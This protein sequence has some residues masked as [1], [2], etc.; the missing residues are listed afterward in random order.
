M[1]GVLIDRASGVQSVVRAFALLEVL[2]S[3]D[4]P[5]GVTDLGAESGLSLGTIHRLLRTL[6][7]LGYVRQDPSRGYALGPGFIKLGER[8]AHGLASW[9][10][11]LL[12][13]LVRELDESV[14]LASLENDQAV[15]VAHVPSSRSMRTFTE[16]GSRV[17]VHSTGVGKAMLASM[18][19][20]QAR[21]LLGRTGMPASTVH[22][23]TDPDALVRELR[24]ISARGYALDEEEQETGVRCVAVP[25]P[26][27]RPPLAVSMSGPS[28]RVTDVLVK[29]A[30]PLLEDVADV[31]AH[32]TSRDEER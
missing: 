6:V 19:E 16:V 24:V 8:A 12:E 21:A 18:P 9:S 14:N 26:G 32:Q 11:P 17:A 20:H 15:Y 27:A 13:K 25:V 1:D 5:L 3:H 22:T 28:A 4:R 23:F 29:R 7:G 30:I 2:A 31:I 10:R